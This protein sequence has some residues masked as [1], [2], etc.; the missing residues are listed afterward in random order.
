MKIYRYELPTRISHWIHVAAMILIMITGL[1]VLTG[2]GFMDSFTVPFHVTLGFIIF[3]ALVLELLTMV[4]NKKDFLLS[5]PTWTDIKNFITIALNFLKLTDKYPR[6]H[7]YSKSKG[8]IKKWHPLLKFIIWGDVI[9]ILI[10]GFTGLAMFYPPDNPLAFLAN[11][12]DLG[13]IRLIHFL[14][15]V[16]F[17]LTVI[18]HAYLGLNPMNRGLLKSMISGW[19][20]GEST[21]IKE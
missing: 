1:Q 4:I 7:V 6:F 13:T 17:V 9:F 16:Y 11:Y 19:D 10:I 12:L 15:F 8:Y 14:C 3:A 5:I 20:D 2:F 21:E 18:P